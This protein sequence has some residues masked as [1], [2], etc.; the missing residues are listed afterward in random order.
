[1]RTDG[2]GQ[3]PDVLIV[4]AGPVG[5][6]LA[7]ELLQQGVR[8]RVVER[9]PAAEDPDPHSKGVLLWPRSLELLRR[10]GVSDQLVAVG[11]RVQRVGYYSAGRL[12]GSARMDRHPDSPY[13][14]VLTLPQ[15]ATERVLRARLTRLGGAIEY[16]VE[17]EHLANGGTRPV[18]L[19]RHA[20]GGT[21]TVTPRWLVGADGPGS[22]VRESLGIDFTGEDVNVT[23]AVG[24]VPLRGEAP[25][26][27]GYYYSR[28]GLVA[29]VPLGAG[30]YRCAA[31][32][33]PAQG[34][35]TADVLRRIIAERAHVDVTVGQPLWTRSFRLRLGLAATLRSGRCLL[36]G[37]SG[38]VISPAGGQGMN[39]GLV[40]AAELGWR[41][42]GVVLG[43]LPES[44]LDSYSTERLA[45]AERMSR[46]SAA[47]TRFASQSKRATILL[48]D[49]V[50][51]GARLTGL[52]RR[53]LVPLLSQ[54]DVTYGRTDPRP[55][56]LGRR[57]TRLPMFA[58]A[59]LPDGTPPLD[60][61]RYT[62]LLSPGH[63]QPPDWTQRVAEARRQYEGRA[64]VCD[65]AALRP[66]S[67]LRL[68]AALVF[69]S[70]L[71]L[72]VTLGKLPTAALVRPDGHLV[73]TCP[74]DRPTDMVP[75]AERVDALA[76]AGSR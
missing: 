39:L 30:M 70:A 46:T 23:Y 12:L 9:R 54:T 27:A 19:L 20:D 50:F 29:L 52:L 37:D 71:D 1:M 44:C 51:V 43:T 28:H 22:L 26:D 21:E 76:T 53:V 32:V 62:V 34:D 57:G 18:A 67:A 73:R 72:R 5:I 68:R 56:R 41:L 15:R 17:L 2:M 42:G 24:D 16:G 63:R 48:R 75:S 60:P 49:M 59:V 45:A 65:L 40:D 61:Y 58:G 14:F 8:V 31:T 10:I 11:H 47:Q 13:P 3:D 25:R 55:V 33:P 7:C 69:R 4:G 74:L 64:Q 35:P 6:V 66:T 36:A 38:H